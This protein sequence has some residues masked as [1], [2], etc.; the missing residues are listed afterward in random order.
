MTRHDHRIWTWLT[1]ASLRLTTSELIRLE[2]QQTLPEPELLGKAGRQ[3]LTNLI[4][5]A[6]TI[7]DRLLD[8]LMESSSARDSTVATLL[9]LLQKHRLI[10]DVRWLPMKNKLRTLPVTLQNLLIYRVALAILALR[11][12]A[13]A[14][15]PHDVHFA[16]PGL[17]LCVTML[18]SAYPAISAL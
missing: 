12:L 14:I 16:L 17:I 1:K 8:T 3:E 9:R 2:E 15:F 11:L 18:V 10:P 5:S 4:Y 7:C 6:D 13:L